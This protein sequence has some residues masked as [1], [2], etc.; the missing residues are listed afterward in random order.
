MSDPDKWPSDIVTKASEESESEAQLVKEIMQAA[1]KREPDELD[2]MLD[3]LSV[4][5]AM[6]VMAWIARFI[7]NCRAVKKQKII[8][9]L[10]T[11]ETNKQLE[12]WIK[13]AQK[14]SKE[15]DSFKE[16]LQ[17]LNLQ[18]ND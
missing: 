12:F 18:Q 16:D 11:V 6:C 9:P 8:G 2:E 7:R 3:K 13:R 15:T 10:T 1:V 4:W 5:K 17:R 14:D